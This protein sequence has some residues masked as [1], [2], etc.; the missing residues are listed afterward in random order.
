MTACDLAA[1]LESRL[2]H[3]VPANL[4][5]QLGVLKQADQAFV[6]TKMQL[7]TCEG[8]ES[9]AGLFEQLAA[10]APHAEQI[11]Y[12]AEEHLASLGSLQV[13]TD[14]NSVL[15]LL[16]GADD[17][18]FVWET[19]DANLSTYLWKSNASLMELSTKPKRFAEEMELVLKQIESIPNLGGRT[20][21]EASPPANFYHFKHDYEED[22]FDGWLGTLNQRLGRLL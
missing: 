12:L 6:D 22:G 15:C 16:A 4:H 21:Y 20:K 18:F 2:E 13:G 9:E 5:Q 8:I 11:A 14:A 3:A 10:D 19:F 7:E 1:Y 17:C